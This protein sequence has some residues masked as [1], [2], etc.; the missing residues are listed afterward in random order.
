[1]LIRI[2]GQWKHSVVAFTVIPFWLNESSEINVLSEEMQW[3][4][5]SQ[6]KNLHMFF[7]WPESLV[8]H[9]DSLIVT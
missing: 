4:V 1:M 5:C 2:T 9:S 6:M 3:T 7:K 8:F